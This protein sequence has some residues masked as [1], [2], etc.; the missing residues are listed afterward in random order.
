M[1][2]NE[3]LKSIDKE[4]GWC[5]DIK[6]QEKNRISKMEAEWFIKGLEQAKSIIEVIDDENY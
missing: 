1:N 6:N 5:S 4:I 3:V 2:K